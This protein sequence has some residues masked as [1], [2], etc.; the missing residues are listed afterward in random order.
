MPGENQSFFQWEKERPLLNP[1]FVDGAGPGPSAAIS[2]LTNL[3]WDDDFDQYASQPEAEVNWTPSSIDWTFEA[4]VSQWLLAAAVGAENITRVTTDILTG[5]EVTVGVIVEVDSGSFELRLGGVV[6]AAG[7]TTSGTF[8]A[9]VVAGGDN[10]AVIVE[11][12]AGAIGA[13]SQVLVG[14]FNE[15]RRFRGLNAGP[16]TVA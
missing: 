13:V 15:Y 11:G 2:L 10:P 5:D 1:Q 12:A 7:I 16:I 9:T 3:I 14:T 4:S 8:I 6:V